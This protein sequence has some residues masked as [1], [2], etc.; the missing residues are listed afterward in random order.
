MSHWQ[1]ALILILLLTPAA[2]VLYE[3]T[4]ERRDALRNPPPGRFVSVG[5]HKLHLL[6]KGTGGP[7]VVIEQGAG[8]PSRLWWPLQDQLAEF[9]A[10]CTYDRAG[11]GWSEQAR[12][13]RTIEQRAEELHA[14]L[15]NASIP[16]PYVLVAHSYGGLI[17]RSFAQKYP[18]LT[19][20]LVL[21]DTPEEATIFRPDVL[22]FYSK[23][24]S[25]LKAVG[26]ASRF[27][28]PRLLSN[29]VS[30]DRIGFPFVRQVEYAA[31]ADDLASLKQLPRPIL[32][33]LGDLPLAVITHGQP[34]PGPFAIVEKGWSEGQVRLA[35]LS[36]DGSLTVAKNSNHMINVDEP[37]IVVEAV[38]RIHKAAGAKRHSVS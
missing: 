13:G 32:G 4:G 6:C 11:Y 2:G 9:A 8:E 23:L 36:T 7:T 37:A 20:G 22:D 24:G 38:R 34:F 5:T 28:V 29:W 18:G 3:R 31:A 26:F 10:V 14:L 30:L 12:A 15:T 33:S 35:G 1:I 27:G 21:V 25:M 16:T 17:V 19:G